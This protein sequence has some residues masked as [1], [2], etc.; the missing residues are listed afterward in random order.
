VVCWVGLIGYQIGG[1]LFGVWQGYKATYR[2][3]QRPP[4]YGLYD[5]ESGAPAK[6]RKVVVQ[7]PTNITVRNI[8]DTVQAYPSDKLTWSG[9]DVDHPTLEGTFDGVPSTIHLRRIDASKFLLVNR[10]FHW[11]NEYPFNR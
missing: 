1:N 10:G 2:N 6:W 4:H 9:A 7:R 11:I 3:P 8:D 5:V